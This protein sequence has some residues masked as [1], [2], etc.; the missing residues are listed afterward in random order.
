MR[1]KLFRHPEVGIEVAAVGVE[2]IVDRGESWMPEAVVSHAA[3][4][5]QSRPEELLS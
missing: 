3:E 4:R 2:R 1:P 5:M